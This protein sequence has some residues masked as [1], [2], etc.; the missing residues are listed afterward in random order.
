L[1]PIQSQCRRLLDFEGL[2]QKNLLLPEQIRFGCAEGLRQKKLLLPEQIIA[3][4]AENLCG[5]KPLMIDHSENRMGCT[6]F[7]VGNCPANTQSQRLH[8]LSKAALH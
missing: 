7:A 5:S 1:D 3:N 4:H 6:F 2:R 8:P